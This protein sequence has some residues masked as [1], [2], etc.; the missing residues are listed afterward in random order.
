MGTHE[1]RRSIGSLFGQ[2]DKDNTLA[3]PRATSKGPGSSAVSIAS[4]DGNDDL[5]KSSDGA[6]DRFRSRQN[7]EDA[8][9]DTDSS[10]HRRRMS[11]IFKS[12]KKR[13]GSGS[14]DDLSQADADEHVP[15]VPVIRHPDMGHPNQSN[16]SLGLAKS[17]ASSLLT[18]DSDTES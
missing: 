6:I 17:V 13:R 12:L 15:P 11:N 2:K 5:R 10:H 16:E 14:Q 9:S 4:S 3:A 1:R 8:R 7:S 18:E